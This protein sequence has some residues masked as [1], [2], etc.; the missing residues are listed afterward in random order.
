M[1]K[2][3]NKSNNVILADAGLLED[4]VWKRALQ[5]YPTSLVCSIREK[6]LKNIPGITEKFNT[7]SRYFGY[8][9]GA[10]KDRAYIYIQKKALRIDLCIS[11]SFKKDIEQNSFE[12]IPRENFQGQAGWLTGWQVPQSTLNLEPVVKWLCK[13][14]EFGDAM[15]NRR[16]DEWRTQQNITRLLNKMAKTDSRAERERISDRIREWTYAFWLSK[17]RKIRRQLQSK[18]SPKIKCDKIQE[19]IDAPKERWVN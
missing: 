14:F 19:I 6:L 7:N 1:N 12:V 2:E 3:P 17:F 15:G 18:S 8:W 13:A 9:I 10:D 4:T 11:P 16:T 5:G